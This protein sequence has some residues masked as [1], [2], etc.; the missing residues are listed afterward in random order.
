MNTIL[1]LPQPRQPAASTSRRSPSL[2]ACWRWPRLVRCGILLIGLL[3]WAPPFLQFSQGGSPRVE[4]EQLKAVYLYNFL[5]FVTWPTDGKRA[6]SNPTMVIGVVGDSPMIQALEELADNLTKMGKDNLDLRHY[7]KYEDGMDLST[8]HV[9]FI[10][11]SEEAHGEQIIASLKNTPVLTVGDTAAFLSA[12]GMITMLEQQDRIRY[13]V[14]R[15]A[16]TA[17]GLRLSSQL[18]KT[19]ISVQDDNPL[20]EQL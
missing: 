8:C 20:G 14:N 9:L 1:S 3:L 15:K 18:L 17:A 2:T 11:A 16:A 5:Q 6:T 19:A 13:H 4:Q 12:G 7:G 10:S